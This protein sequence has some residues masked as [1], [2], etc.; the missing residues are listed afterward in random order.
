MEKFETQQEAFKEKRNNK[1]K[2]N[3]GKRNQ[4]K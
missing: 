4:K 3:K 1:S 2:M